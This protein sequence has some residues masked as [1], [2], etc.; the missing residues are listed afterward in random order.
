MSSLTFGKAAFGVNVGRDMILV[1]GRVL[2]GTPVLYKK[3][4]SLTT[5][6]ASWNMINKNFAVPGRVSKWSFLALGNTAFSNTYLDQFRTA[7]RA[8]G[9]GEETPMTP[10]GS[11]RPGYH[12][13]LS[14]NEENND[15]SIMNAFRAMKQHGVRYLLVILPLRSQVLYS[16]V[17]FW[18]DVKAGES[19]SFRGR[20]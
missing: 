10:P 15:K 14:E 12:V 13:T 16:R 5:V 11:S 20:N 1:A 8:T 18:A 6:G 9:M 17:K 19:F 7:L 4:A 2:D 3:N